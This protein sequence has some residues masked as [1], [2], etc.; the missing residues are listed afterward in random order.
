[1][2]MNER[3]GGIG[4]VVRQR[5]LYV[6][7]LLWLLL[8]GVGLLISRHT[9]SYRGLVT[10]SSKYL[11]LVMLMF[12]LVALLTRK[13]PVIDLAQRA[14]ERYMARRETLAMWAYVAVVMVAGRLIGQHLFGEGLALHLNGSLVGATRVQ[15]PIEVY[16]WAAYNGI[17]LALIPYVVFRM[18]G[19]SNQQLNLKSANLKSDIIVIAVVLAIGCFMDL[20]L[21]GNFLRLT[22]HQQIAGG[23]MS[24]VL[25]LFGT[26]LPVMIFIFS[27]LLPRSAKLTA[28]V[29]AFLLGAASYP[30]MHV[31]ESWTR[32]DSLA[33]SALSVIVVF[34]FFFPPGLMKSFLTLRTG[35]AW[36]HVWGFHAI[37]PHVTVD[38]RLIV[39]DFDIR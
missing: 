34:L 39:R 37:S 17:L 1:M 36:V 35:N 22:H 12:G 26:D 11:V 24:F 9:P 3:F 7:I 27:V 21:N 2:A 10:G 38:T 28:P 29:T 8:C 16:T 15:S 4:W 5:A 25:H 23:L 31:F 33:H 6:A 32:Y 30:A 18:R 20:T 13:R 19:Y 14:P